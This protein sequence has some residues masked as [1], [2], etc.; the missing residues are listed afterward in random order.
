[1]SR[2]DGSNS[3]GTRGLNSSW[4]GAANA[5]DNIE[6]RLAA[7]RAKGHT[8]VTTVDHTG[9]RTLTVDGRTYGGATLADCLTAAGL[10]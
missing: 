3:P 1:M 8:I 2:P 10:A 6:E 7:L 9:A 5:A 4:I